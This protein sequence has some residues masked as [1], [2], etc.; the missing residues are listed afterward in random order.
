MSYTLYCYLYPPSLRRRTHQHKVMALFAWC[1]N[2]KSP[3]IHGSAEPRG[4]TGTGNAVLQ[5]LLG[6]PSREQPADTCNPAHNSLTL[7]VPDMGTQRVHLWPHHK[8][9]RSRNTWCIPGIIIA[10]GES[11]YRL[12]PSSPLWAV[13]PTSYL[14]FLSTR[15]SSM[16]NNYSWFLSQSE[17]ETTRGKKPEWV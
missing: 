7:R 1:K 10:P 5:A 6:A 17:T 11:I 2:C 3:P 16:Q 8:Q 12:L 13:A 9:E 15:H 14:A 4:T